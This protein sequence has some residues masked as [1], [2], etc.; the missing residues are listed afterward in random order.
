[1]FLRSALI[2]TVF[3]GGEAGSDR[4]SWLFIAGS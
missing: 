4:A 2:T 3:D 1:M